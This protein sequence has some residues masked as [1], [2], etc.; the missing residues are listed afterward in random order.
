MKLTEKDFKI[1]AATILGGVDAPL[2]ADSIEW[3]AHEL[4]ET[5]KQ[6]FEEATNLLT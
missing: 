3:L 1:S 5:Y 4:F 6:G 2:T